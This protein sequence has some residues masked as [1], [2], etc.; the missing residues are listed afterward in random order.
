MKKSETALKRPFTRWRAAGC[1]PA[2]Q[3]LHRRRRA[4]RDARGLVPAAAVR[5]HGRQRARADPGRR[6]RGDRAGADARRVPQRQARPEVRSRG[7]RGVPAG[8]PGVRLPYHFPGAPRVH[9]L[10]QG[11]VP[12]RH[13]GR[14]A[15]GAAR[16]GEVSAVPQPVVV[17]AGARVWRLAEGVRRAAAAAA[18]RRSAARTCSTFPSTTRRTSKAGTRS[19]PG[20]SLCRRCAGSS[21][22]SEK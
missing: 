16:R 7:D 10:R 13:R 8:R 12:G 18:S 15:A 14:A 6:R 21:P 11:P 3:R 5:G 20:R 22:W 4:R 17:G 19:S 9:R 1:A 2:D